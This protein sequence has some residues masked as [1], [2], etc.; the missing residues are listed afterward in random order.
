MFHNRLI[1]I[2]ALLLLCC[3]HSFSFRSRS[4]SKPY[5]KSAV[6]VSTQTN[7]EKL[8]D[9]YGKAINFDPNTLIKNYE[10]GIFNSTLVAR[11]SE[12]F[13]ADESDLDEIMQTP[14]LRRR[15]IRSFSDDTAGIGATFLGV[16]L[17]YFWAHGGFLTMTLCGMAGNSLSSRTDSIGTVGRI[18]GGLVHSMFRDLP[19]GN[20]PL[21][22]D[23]MEESSKSDA[24]STGNTV[25]ESL[26]SKLPTVD[27]A[28]A[29]LQNMFSNRDSS[30][31][32]P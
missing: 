12:L 5:S 6:H 30:N 7:T 20:I 28:K 3:V 32:R 13:G 23:I 14:E 17:G 29:A 31:S 1:T 9:F 22:K 10:E 18:A 15:L 16:F 8:A 4:F 24:G 21:L 25:L 27:N 11:A 26:T 2:V 19:R